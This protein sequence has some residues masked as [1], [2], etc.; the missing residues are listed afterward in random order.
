M[1]FRVKRGIHTQGGVVYEAGKNDIVDSDIDL[2]KAFNSAKFERCMVPI[3]DVETAAV[4]SNDVS[5]EFPG[6]N[7]MGLVIYHE[8]AQYFV[9]DINSNNP[10]HQTKITQKDAVRELVEGL[11]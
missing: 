3:E 6:C 7:E 4:F 11:K 10:V 9:V 8:N 5:N 2:I 1:K